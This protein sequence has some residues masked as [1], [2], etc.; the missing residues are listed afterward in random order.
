MTL[1][2]RRMLRNISVAGR[3]FL[4]NRFHGIILKPSPLNSTRTSN[5][6]ECQHYV[7]SSPPGLSMH[8]T[9]SLQCTAVV[10]KYTYNPLFILKALLNIIFSCELLKMVHC[11]HKLV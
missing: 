10:N 2:G 8:I 4:S 6:I 1:K 11:L 9:L 3:L 7:H 5:V